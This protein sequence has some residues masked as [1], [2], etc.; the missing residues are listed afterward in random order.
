MA[1]ETVWLPRGL[2]LGQKMSCSRGAKSVSL[3]GSMG[4]CTIGASDQP[5]VLGPVSSVLCHHQLRNL[6]FLFR[7]WGSNPEPCAC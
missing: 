7:C 2:G 1:V 6:T 3:H 5:R 4:P